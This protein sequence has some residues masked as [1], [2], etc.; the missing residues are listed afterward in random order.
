MRRLVPQLILL[1]ITVGAPVASVADEVDDLIRQVA[2][3]N[4]LSQWW[5][6]DTRELAQRA[7]TEATREHGPQDPRVASALEQLARLDLHDAD[8]DRARAHLE[9]A[10]AIRRAEGD[11]LP[12][13]RGLATLAEVLVEQED[14]DGAEV[15]LT[16]AD[17]LQ[18]RTLGPEHPDLAVTLQVRGILE[19]ARGDY[20]AA[21]QHLDRAQ[22]IQETDPE[23]APELAETLINQGKRLRYQ[24]LYP[25]ALTVVD[26]T[27]AV[28]E[29]NLGRETPVMA[30]VLDLQ[31]TLHYLTADLT[32]A[33]TEWEEALRIQRA[34]LGP[35]HAQ[36]GTTLSNLALVSE[37][38]RALPAARDQLE[39]ALEVYRRALGPEHSILSIVLYNLARVN[40]KLGDFAVARTHLETAITI[41]EAALG[42]DHPQIGPLALDLARLLEDTGDH[43]GAVVH[44]ERALYLFETNL[45]PDHP[46]VAAVL[47]SL[48]TNQQRLGRPEEAKPIL[49]R[50]IAINRARL[51]ADHPWVSTIETH[52]AD[53]LLL[54]GDV[55]P[56]LEIYRKSLEIRTTALG[57]DHPYVGYAHAR[58]AR[59]HREA[60]RPAESLTASLTAERIARRHLRTVSRSLAEREA[61]RYAGITD[62]GLATALDLARDGLDADDVGR[63][64]DAVVRSRALVLDAMVG[65]RR[66]LRDD[67]DAGLAPLREEYESAS[68]DLARLTVREL[69]K[70]D[71]EQMRATLEEAQRRQE[72]AERALLE[73]SPGFREDQRRQEAGLDAVRAALPDDS[74]LV[75]YVRYGSR[76]AEIYLAFVASGSGL[77]CVDLGDATGVDLLVEDWRRELADGSAGSLP[78]GDALRE[79]IWDPVAAHLGSEARVFVVLDGALHLV[80][81]ATLPD[82]DGRYLLET[83]PLFHLLNA[84]RDVLVPA[85]PASGR[86]LLALGGPD[87]DGV[88]SAG[89]ESGRRGEPTDCTSFQEIRFP[90]L[91]GTRIELDRVV[92]LWAAHEGSPVRRLQGIEATESALKTSAPGHRVLHL[93]THGFYLGA[94]CIEEEAGTR[95]VGGVAPTRASRRGFRSQDG[96]NP[97][98]LSGVALAGANRRHEAGEGEDDGIL[99]SGELAALDL[100]GVEW[101]VLSACET[102]LGEIGTG[103]GVFGLRRAL[104]LAGA[105]TVVLS[106]W[107]VDDLAA[108][109]WMQELYRARLVERLDTAEAV[110]EAGLRVLERRRDRGESDHPFFWGAFIAAGDW[111]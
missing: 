83:G 94:G 106:L 54:T 100:E 42:P 46:H 66:A 73:A 14:L 23:Y 43:E 53:I 38:F 80:N 45:G 75:S 82:A 36:L 87:F 98:R 60:G 79:R 18:T 63:V 76:D 6:P 26:R 30:R 111:R 29:A 56:A 10:V 97:L 92:D 71:V 78:A 40:R 105:R 89:V 41:R 69:G 4:R 104:Q 33:Q 44:L 59:A 86:G 88:G 77:T 5:Q 62:S 35:D 52:L 28:V 109:A 58:L 81:L 8:F 110:R 91:P 39:Q 72:R 70:D 7:L 55:D 101:A 93:A 9:R 61:L 34:T 74:A 95:G 37:S 20:D 67:N 103:E 102:G 96:T 25:E 108:Q 51:G 99:T 32:A 65:R 19:L 11:P 64:W 22:A 57:P 13:A 2:Q 107:A 85:T 21:G 68:R 16:E 31:A 17:E 12:L 1:L 24:G 49:E 47:A 84:E 50:A 3:R 48:A 27:L 90:S 15:P